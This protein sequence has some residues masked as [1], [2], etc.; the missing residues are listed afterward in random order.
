V[1]HDDTSGRAPWLSYSQ[2]QTFRA[3]P[4]KWNY[5]TR[6]RL[7]KV[8]R[9]S[10]RVELNFGSWWHALLAADSLERGRASGSLQE[11]GTP[12]WVSAGDD[13]PRWAG[14]GLTV[15][16]VLES[17]DTWWDAVPGEDAEVWLAKLG[18]PLPARLIDLFAAYEAR[19]AGDRQHEAP[20]AVELGWR[21]DLPELRPDE[22]TAGVLVGYVDEVYLDRLR[23]LVVVRDHKTA[24]ALGTQTTADDMMDSQ[25]Q[26]YAWG[27]APAINAWGQG[28]VRAT[29]YD[30]ARSVAPK[31]PHLTLAGRLAVYQGEPSI[32]QCDLA[33]YLSWSRGPDGDGVRYPGTRKDGSNAGWYRAEESVVERLATPAAQSVWF[34]RTLS[35]LNVNLIKAHLRAAVDSALDIHVQGTRVDETREAARNLGRG[36]RWCDYAGLCRAEMVGG[37]DGEYDLADYGLRVRP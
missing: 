7:S 28:Q 6:R 11:G 29:G 8:E 13:G 26:F 2:L 31:P 35:P 9:I 34:Q 20:L 1:T 37:P 33:T 23:R 10:E 32:G 22:G 30:R 17:A 19:W 5:S 18:Q 24:S 15:D 21:R 16:A 25:L 14:E 3:C 4:Q 12:Q 36:C 27:A